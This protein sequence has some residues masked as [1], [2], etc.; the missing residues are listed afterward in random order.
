MHEKKKMQS[1][2]SNTQNLIQKTNSFSSLPEDQ[3]PPN[4]TTIVLNYLIICPYSA[5]NADMKIIFKLCLPFQ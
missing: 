5:Y 4:Y 2:K 3:R 1:F